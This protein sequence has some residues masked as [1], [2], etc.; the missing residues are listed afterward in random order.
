MCCDPPN[1]VCGTGLWQLIVVQPATHVLGLE[2]QCALY[3][4]W[5]RLIVAD[6]SCQWVCFMQFVAGSLFAA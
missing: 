1:F 4:I 3:I 6:V 2:V 5:Y